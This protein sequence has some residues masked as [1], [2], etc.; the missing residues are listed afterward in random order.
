VLL[1]D[2]DVER[3]VHERDLHVRRIMPGSDVVNNL[4]L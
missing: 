3:H 2:D 1:A 4:R